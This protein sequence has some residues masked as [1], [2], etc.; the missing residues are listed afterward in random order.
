MRG[1][2][3]ILAV[4]FFQRQSSAHELK[5]PPGVKHVECHQSKECQNLGDVNCNNS[6]IRPKLAGIQVFSANLILFPLQTSKMIHNGF[7]SLCKRTLV[8]VTLLVTNSASI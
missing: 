5:S 8:Q 6:C 3:I 2:S 4:L 1:I 7:S